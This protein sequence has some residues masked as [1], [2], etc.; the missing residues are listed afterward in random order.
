VPVVYDSKDLDD[1]AIGLGFSFMV[2]ID[3]SVQGIF[4]ECGGLTATIAVEKWEEG[5]VNTHAHQFPG[6]ATFENISLKQAVFA[7]T[8]L[9]D[10]FLEV[11]QGT[12]AR[13]PI[14]VILADSEG[15]EVRR[16]EFSDAFPVKWTGPALNV[17][18]NDAAIET[19]EFAH[20]G[21]IPS[22]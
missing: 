3:G 18:S 10:W 12:L 20:A 19:L 13:K 15:A 6:R 21:L 16:W 8:D 11:A 5:G 14:S 17:T 22:G 1:V 4:T 2:E 9:Y 7:S